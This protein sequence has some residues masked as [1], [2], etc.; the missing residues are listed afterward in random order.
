M[1]IKGAFLILLLTIATVG[2]ITSTDGKIIADIS[3]IS[4]RSYGY[5]L[6]IKEV[7]YIHDCVEVSF[8]KTYVPCL[9]INL[10]ITNNQKESFYFAMDKGV[11]VTKDGKQYYK[12]GLLGEFYSSSRLSYK[13][14]V[15]SFRDLFVGGDSLFPS[16]RRDIGLCFP[17]VSVND[18][19][20]FYVGVVIGEDIGVVGTGRG[21]AK[22]HSF[23]LTNY[24]SNIT[25]VEP[26]M[27]RQILQQNSRYLKS[28][29]IQT[30]KDMVKCE[31]DNHVYL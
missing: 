7:K 29:K 19:P 18:N 15:D 13:P 2:C 31:S 8:G 17:L 23:D 9:F 27:G 22:E 28:E 5:G 10:E 12:Y 20:K 26:S 6:W 3:K 1:G 4:P 21:Q 14:C 16:A 30:K 24:L 25:R 11:I